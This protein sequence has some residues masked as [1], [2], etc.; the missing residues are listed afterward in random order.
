MSI[1][2]A[3]AARLFPAL[4]KGSERTVC[5][6]PA[7][8]YSWE[9]FIQC[10][11]GTEI[12]PDNTGISIIACANWYRGYK[13][14]QYQFDLVENDEYSGGKASELSDV[15]ALSRCTRR[16][17]GVAPERNNSVAVLRSQD[18]A[19]GSCTVWR[20]KFWYRLSDYPVFASADPQNQFYLEVFVENSGET[21]PTE[22]VWGREED[23]D[24]FA[25]NVWN[26][27]E[28]IFHRESE[29]FAVYWFAYHNNDCEVDLKSIAVDAMGIQ[30]A[31]P[32]TLATGICTG[33][34]TVLTISTTITPVEG[35]PFTSA[36][37]QPFAVSGFTS[38]EPTT[39]EPTT[40][41]TFA[42]MIAA[43]IPTT[44]AATTLLSPF[45][46][47]LQ[48]AVN[49]ENYPNNT[50][51]YVQSTHNVLHTIQ[52]GLNDANTELS[53]SDIVTIANFFQEFSGTDIPTNLSE[54]AQEDSINT[55]L[56]IT[57]QIFTA[58]NSGKIAAPTANDEGHSAAVSI[59]QALEDMFNR[60]QPTEEPYVFNDASFAVYANVAKVNASAQFDDLHLYTKMEIA[61]FNHG[62][63]ILT[64]SNESIPSLATIALK[65]DVLREA[66]KAL[67]V[68]KSASKLRFYWN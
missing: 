67:S 3:S 59:Y 25:P 32:A 55:L 36:P 31:A 37:S 46:L 64:G 45:S 43:T 7:P 10:S 13:Y 60:L 62:K 49:K 22:V 4:V 38:S 18:I 51:Y 5:S 19:P 11:L 54:G 16:P 34:S 21:F 27:G 20:V 44:P 28:A 68:S 41:P 40:S 39:T 56:Q 50:S 6:L 58:E 14:Y 53:F 1:Q 48:N 29:A 66:F 30:Y 61:G 63:L 24:G 12:Q 35:S 47:E 9:T 8:C 42:A 52:S 26:I 2:G 15:I 23:Y 33:P 17:F 57:S 65:D